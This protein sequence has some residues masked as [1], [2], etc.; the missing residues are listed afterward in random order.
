MAG[1]GTF[2]W[3]RVDALASQGAPKGDFPWLEARVTPRNTIFLAIRHLRRLTLLLSDDL[4]DLSQPVTVTV[5][6]KRAYQG[7]LKADLKAL[8][9]SWKAGDRHR[10]KAAALPLELSP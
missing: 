8:A 9:G 1:P 6:G 3:V 5:N 7:L 10:P 2:G 4:V